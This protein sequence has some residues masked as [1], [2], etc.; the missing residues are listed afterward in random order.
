MSQLEA[1]KPQQTQPKGLSA[2]PLFASLSGGQKRC[3]NCDS[4][5]L[6]WFACTRNTG[7]VQ[8]GLLN[9]HDVAPIFVLGCSE[10]SETLRVV[11]G[12]D[13]AALLNAMQAEANVSDQATASARRC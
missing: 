7:G 1:A 8:D 9:M 3:K 13:V 4:D 5:Q 2:P 10:C 6:E 11:R 12:D